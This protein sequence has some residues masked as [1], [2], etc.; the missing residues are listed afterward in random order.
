MNE[1]IK[2]AIEKGGYN[3]VIW[4]DLY[5]Q[6]NFQDGDGGYFVNYE[7]ILMDKDFW[8]S[9]GKA[10]GWKMTQ[11]FYQCPKECEGKHG[12]LYGWQSGCPNCKGKL[13]ER[14]FPMGHFEDREDMYYA[15]KYF[16]LV[17]TGGDTEKF[18][19]EL[20]TSTKD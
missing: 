7:K 1:A 11:K 15:R 12:G 10:L 17:L 2:L 9:L 20:L 4:D 6:P 16:R 19:E 3:K 14:D 13:V 5:E 8:E 18:W